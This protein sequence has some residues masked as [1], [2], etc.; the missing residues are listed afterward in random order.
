MDW[1]EVQPMQSV[2]PIADLIVT[3]TGQRDVVTSA[4]F[5]TAKDGCLLANAGHFQRQNQRRHARRCRRFAIKS[6]P[7]RRGVP[8]VRRPT[9]DGSTCWPM[10]GSSISLGPR[11][12]RLP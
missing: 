12:T 5:A 10:V 8:N 7:Q 3:A 4:H 6:A 11:D 1:F 2:A 9:A